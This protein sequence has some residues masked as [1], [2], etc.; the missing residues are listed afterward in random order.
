MRA[1]ALTHLSNQRL[2]A[3]DLIWNQRIA[4]ALG[5]QS[6]YLRGMVF[7]RLCFLKPLASDQLNHLSAALVEGCGHHQLFGVLGYPHSQR[8]AAVFRL[9]PRVCA[10][11]Q[12]H[13]LILGNDGDGSPPSVRED[14]DHHHR[15]HGKAY[16]RPLGVL[17]YLLQHRDHAACDQ[18]IALEQLQTFEVDASRSRS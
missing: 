15:A 12:R 10:V 18:K 2:L 14:Y 16:P 9:H 4:L 8:Y 6:H 17:A 7:H 3:C 1:A 13:R 5:S 11:Y